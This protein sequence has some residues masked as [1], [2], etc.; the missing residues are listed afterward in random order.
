M[1]KHWKYQILDLKP[2]RALNCKNNTVKNDD[3]L[4]GAVIRITRFPVQT[5]LGTWRG[6]EPQPY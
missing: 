3:N 2:K 1:E 6:L 5:P 4:W